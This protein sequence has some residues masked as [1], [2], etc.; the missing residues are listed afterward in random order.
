MTVIQTLLRRADHCVR[1]S[2]W[3]DLA[4]IKLCL[5]A[6]GVLLGL[7]V[8]PRRKKPAALAAGLV[9]VPTYLLLLARYLPILL[10]A[11]KEE[12]WEK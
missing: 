3:K 12:D 10:W 7:A 9:F 4:L 8:T 1:Q 6:L 2:T 5:G 11:G